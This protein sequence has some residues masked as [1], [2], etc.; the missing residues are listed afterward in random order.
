LNRR[1]TFILA[2]GVCLVASTFAQRPAVAQTFPDISQYE[3]PGRDFGGRNNGDP[4]VPFAPA[5]STSAGKLTRAKADIET[6]TAGDGRFS[7]SVPMWR[8][9]VV[10]Q[11]LRS[12][13][14]R[15]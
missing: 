9:R 8:L 1:W 5:K 13:Y 12:F 10:L 6:R 4:D 15:F 2:L 11:G 3:D 7:R 14:F